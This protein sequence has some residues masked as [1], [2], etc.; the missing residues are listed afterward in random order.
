MIRLLRALL[1]RPAAGIEA[2]EAEDELEPAPAPEPEPPPGLGLVGLRAALAARLRPG[3]I[4]VVVYGEAV[5]A[6]QTAAA[7]NAGRTHVV[8]AVIGDAPPAAPVEA[9]PAIC[10]A[11]GAR[12]VVIAGGPCP[13]ERRARLDAA[14]RAAEAD[15][16][17]APS[18]ADVLDGVAVRARRAFDVAEL[19]SRPGE[20]LCPR[21]VTD[22]IEGRSALVTGAG[23]SIGSA[24]CRQLLA[25]R[26]RRLTLYEMSEFALYQIERELR[27]IQ[28]AGGAP[29]GCEI[30]PVLGSV[31]DRARLERAIDRAEADLLYHAA[32]YKHVPLVETNAIEGL[33]NNVVGSLRVVEAAVA[34]GVRN[35]VMVSTDKA[36]RPTNVM[37]ATK[38]LAE[39]IA[40]DAQ[41][42]AAGTVFAIVRFGNVLGSSGSVIP[43]FA[44]Q[45]ERGGPVTVT[46]PEMTRYFMSIPEA[47]SLVV[48]AGAMA[49]G[50][51]VFLLDMGEPVRILDMARRMIE[52]A[53]RRPL[54]PGET[55]A[56]VPIVFT[57]VR[58][59]EKLYEEL[60]IDENV[61]PSP[62]PK[63]A[64]A[65]ETCPPRA[66][67]RAHLA[68]IERAIAQGDVAAGV[69]ALRLATEHYAP[70]QAYSDPA[71]GDA[72][73]AF[74]RTG[75]GA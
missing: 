13:P 6:R 3:R 11:S 19:L 32:A 51:E 61:L 53:G 29:A 50:G 56:G 62:H 52:L 74:R 7:L 68:Q 35:V 36:V 75:L 2:R 73:T 72:A 18:M 63:I 24:L 43:L 44:S 40:Q 12:V 1:S 27:A 31:C 33:R 30:V 47:A 28:A 54:L 42:D 20:A 5:C 39:M 57:G 16:V 17:E 58:E 38:R 22:R 4:P 14:L 60:L 15:S 71:A 8:A 65:Q 23:G 67:L 64:R 34:R 21:G 69:E 26:P 9:L 46:H 37:G 48:Q 70:S 45:I 55:G 59:G 10:R 49:Q 66:V 25:C 41:R